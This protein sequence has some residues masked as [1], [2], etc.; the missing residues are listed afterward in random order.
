MPR[1]TRRTEL[2]RGSPRR[3][4]T[5]LTSKVRQKQSADIA[6]LSMGRSVQRRQFEFKVRVAM[7]FG[8]R[9][10]SDPVRPVILIERIQKFLLDSRMKMPY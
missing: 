4:T 1:R 9:S 7:F 3:H 6:G 10:P 5:L 2:T 8:P